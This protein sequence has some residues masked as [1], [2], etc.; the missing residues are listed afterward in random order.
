MSPDFKPRHGRITLS[1]IVGRG[2]LNELECANEGTM[3]VQ[4]DTPV[5]SV[6]LYYV[7]LNAGDRHVSRL[8]WL[9]RRMTESCFRRR[10]AVLCWRCR[11]LQ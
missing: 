9:G 4:G 6:G 1:S 3:L 10:N 7:E 8:F 11:L 2:I 5:C